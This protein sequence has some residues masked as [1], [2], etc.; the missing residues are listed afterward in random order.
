MELTHEQLCILDPLIN[1]LLD[2][3]L[4]TVSVQEGKIDLHEYV[5]LYFLGGN[6]LQICDNG[7]FKCSNYDLHNLLQN[8]FYVGVNTALTT[9][10]ST[11]L[12]ATLKPV[13]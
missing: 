5:T 10:P 8:T 12:N 4:Y 7:T 6:W 3:G 2:L 13:K 11:V 1:K 9:E